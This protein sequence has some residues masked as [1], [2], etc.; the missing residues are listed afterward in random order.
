[1]PLTAVR[2]CVRNIIN[3]IFF[4]QIFITIHIF[5]ASRFSAS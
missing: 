4:F 3:T 2:D 5:V 1:M